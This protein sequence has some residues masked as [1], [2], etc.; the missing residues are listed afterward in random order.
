MA[1]FRSVAGRRKRTANMWLMSVT[2]EV[3]KFSGWLKASV[4]CGVQRGHLTEGS[5]CGT[6]MWHREGRS[7]QQR[8]QHAACVCG[9]QPAGVK[10]Q[11]ET[12]SEHAAHV[13]DA[14]GVEA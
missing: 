3:S 7:I 6:E 5:T 10:A 9:P 13:Y 12:H 8:A 4:P 11:A 1:Q 2:L 14:G